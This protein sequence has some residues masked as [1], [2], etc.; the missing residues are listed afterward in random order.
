VQQQLTDAQAVA[1]AQK[2]QQQLSGAHAIAESAQAGAKKLQE[3]LSGAVTS[4]D[5]DAEKLQQQLAEAQAAGESALADT[6]K[7]QQQQPI[8]LEP[9]IEQLMAAHH[10]EPLAEVIIVAPCC[11]DTPCC[12]DT[13]SCGDIPWTLLPCL[14]IQKQHT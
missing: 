10:A 6:K 8:Q 13:P 4:D 11:G 2:L 9:S 14:C 1:S 5:L 7:L 3:Q 12:D